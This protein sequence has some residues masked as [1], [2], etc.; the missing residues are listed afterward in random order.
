[1]DKDLACDI[2]SPSFKADQDPPK[3]KANE[4]VVNCPDKGTKDKEGGAKI[5]KKG[6]REDG[7][8]DG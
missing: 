1:M 3:G 2:D 8:Q 4:D 6:K 7:P 5:N